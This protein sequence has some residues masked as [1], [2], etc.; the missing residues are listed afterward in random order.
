MFDREMKVTQYTDSNPLVDIILLE[1]KLKARK[2]PL[3]L[4]IGL[5]GRPKLPQDSLD[6]IRALSQKH[7]FPVVC[8]DTIGLFL[9]H[10]L[11]TF[12]DIIIASLGGFF[13]GKCNVSGGW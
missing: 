10:N 6:Q 12:V 8:V 9:N 5:P 4:F 2:V 13:S 1:N 3:A 11:F 7:D